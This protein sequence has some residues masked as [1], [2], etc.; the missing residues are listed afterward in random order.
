M[1]TEIYVIVWD[2]EMRGPLAIRRA[3][4]LRAARAVADEMYQDYQW[5]PR[6]SFFR[7]VD[8]TISGDAIDKPVIPPDGWEAQEA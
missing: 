5:S 4:N 2:L 7:E 3:A 1:N 8:A 6:I